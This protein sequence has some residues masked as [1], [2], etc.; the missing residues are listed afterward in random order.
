MPDEQV[1][2]ILTII[3][4]NPEFFKKMAEDIQHKVKSGMSQEAAMQAF[5]SAHKDE[6]QTILG[7]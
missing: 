7:K 2:Q 6:L 3:E 5:M 1:E 4:K